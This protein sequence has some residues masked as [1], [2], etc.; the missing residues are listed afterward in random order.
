[1][2]RPRQ[3]ANSIICKTN[4]LYSYNK[5]IFR[6]K[7]F[8]NYV[9]LIQEGGSLSDAIN[10]VISEINQEYDQ[11]LNHPQEKILLDRLIIWCKGSFIWH[12]RQY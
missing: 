2:N 12:Y 11:L 1:L 5:D 6:D 7:T 9:Y 10:K 3:L 4:D 8:F